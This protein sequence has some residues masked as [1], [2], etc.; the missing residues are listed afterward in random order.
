MM[1][2]ADES[3]SLFWALA[4]RTKEYHGRQ[5][6]DVPFIIKIHLLINLNITIINPTVI[7]AKSTTYHPSHVPTIEVE[8]RF[9]GVD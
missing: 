5:F 9:V 1:K 8:R 6:E 3:C 4:Y 7:S 2:D